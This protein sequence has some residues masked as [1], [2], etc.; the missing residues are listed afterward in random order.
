MIRQDFFSE[1]FFGGFFLGDHD[2]WP[3][4]ALPVVL[5]PAPRYREILERKKR[6]SDSARDDSLIIDDESLQSN[7]YRMFEPAEEVR[8]ERLAV[9]ASSKDYDVVPKATIA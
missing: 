3:L 7:S 8:P 2:R 5:D 6:N 9:D 4:Y 1:I